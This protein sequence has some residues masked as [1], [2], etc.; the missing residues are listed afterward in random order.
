MNAFYAQ[1]SF[2]IVNLALFK[3]VF[4]VYNITK[5]RNLIK[6]VYINNQKIVKMVIVL[7]QS[8]KDANNA[9]LL[10]PIVR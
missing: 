1:L 8:A 2:L 5:Y 10:V 6:V 3:I 7:I 4:N 9:T